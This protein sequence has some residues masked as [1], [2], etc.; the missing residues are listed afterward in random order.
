MGPATP[1]SGIKDSSSKDLIA[2]TRL[3]HIEYNAGT[4]L[5]NPFMSNN[6]YKL[7][8][9][10]MNFPSIPSICYGTDLLFDLA[11][12]RDSEFLMWFVVLANLLGVNVC[13]LFVTLHPRVYK[14]LKSREPCSAIVMIFG[15]FG[16]CSGTTVMV[17]L[18]LILPYL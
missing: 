13:L 10:G 14:Q 17:T 9:N 3:E 11:V 5:F 16:F 8:Q 6:I 2:I 15:V 12:T 1:G 7:N 4:T 18:I